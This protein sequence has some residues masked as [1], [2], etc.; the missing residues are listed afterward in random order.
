MWWKES[1]ILSFLFPDPERVSF[2]FQAPAALLSG[3][4]PLLSVK[5]E[6]GLVPE[7]G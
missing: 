3:K 6:V 4:E 7:P 1:T 5:Q 2:Q